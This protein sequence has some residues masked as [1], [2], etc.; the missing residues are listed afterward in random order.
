MRS[1]KQVSLPPVPHKISIDPGDGGLGTTVKATGK[2][3]KNGTSLTVFR[4]SDDDGELTLFDDDVLCVD[5]VIAGNIG[6]CD[7]I[8]THPTF[9]GKARITT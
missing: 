5:N 8:V 9:E 6:T 2:G 4:D 3:F 1:R 7:F